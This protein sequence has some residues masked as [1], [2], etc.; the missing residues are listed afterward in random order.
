MSISLR[1]TTLLL[2]GLIVPVLAHAQTDTMNTVAISEFA[3]LFNI[4]VGL[5]FVVAFTM[6]VGGVITYVIYFGN[7]ERDEGVELMKWGVGVLFV[8]VVL[9]GFAQFIQGHGGVGNVLVAIVIIVGAV[10][11]AAVLAADL[12]SGDAKKEEKKP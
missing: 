11:A 2:L 9:L 4:V 3:G 12:S 8:L 5:M 10:W 1:L 6:F 7:L